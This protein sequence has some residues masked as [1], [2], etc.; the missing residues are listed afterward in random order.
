MAQLTGAAAG[1]TVHDVAWAPSLGRCVKRCCVLVGERENES[2]CVCERETKCERERERH[3]V[4][5]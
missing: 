2:G 1:Q 3:C 5:E 4:Y